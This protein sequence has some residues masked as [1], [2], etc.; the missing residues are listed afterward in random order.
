[1]LPYARG[2]SLLEGDTLVPER[3]VL[4]SV[5]A[6]E[7]ASG[8]GGGGPSLGGRFGLDC[9]FLFRELGAEYRFA[10]AVPFAEF[11]G[12]PSSRV[13]LS[14]CSISG[15]SPPTLGFGGRRFFFKLFG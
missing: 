10:A 12:K 14:P 6:R 7:T 1:M 8:G 3:Y 9:C 4:L 15:N 5:D 11:G 2:L 13:A